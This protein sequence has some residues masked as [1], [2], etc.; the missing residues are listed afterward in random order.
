MEELIKKITGTILI[1]IL[2]WTGL[3][4]INSTK[5]TVDNRGKERIEEIN[6]K[7]LREKCTKAVEKFNKHN[8]KENENHAIEQCKKAEMP[9]TKSPPKSP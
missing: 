1:I 7:A 4:I 2:A 3:T 9:K 8:S 5:S 6:K